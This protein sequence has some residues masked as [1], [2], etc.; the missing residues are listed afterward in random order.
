MAC[1]NDRNQL[2]NI[3]K[4]SKKLENEIICGEPAENMDHNKSNTFFYGIAKY[5]IPG[6]DDE[7]EIIDNYMVIGYEKPI[8]LN[9]IKNMFEC[10]N[11]EKRD[12]KGV[13]EKGMGVKHFLHKYADI[14][15]VISIKGNMI[16]SYYNMPLDRHINDLK[17]NKNINVTE[18]MMKLET[19]L[20]NQQLSRIFHSYPHIKT[21]YDKLKKSI[22]TFN[23]E[24]DENIKLPNSI[25]IIKLL[26]D[27]HDIENIYNDTKKIYEIKYIRKMNTYNYLLF[28]NFDNNEIYNLEIIKPVDLLMYKSKRDS[29]KFY[30][31]KY[32]QKYIF[33]FK[34]NNYF[35][36]YNYI[37]DGHMGNTTVIDKDHELYN[38]INN[39]NDN[40]EDFNLEI[41][42]ID[43]S[44]F[45]FFKDNIDIKN[46]SIE[47][48]TGFYFLLDNII[49]N[50]SPC[51]LIDVMN[52]PIRSVGG[53]STR[54][55]IEIKNKTIFDLRGVK[56]EFSIKDKKQKDIIK[57]LWNVLWQSHNNKLWNIKNYIPINKLI[58]SDIIV[59]FLEN[60]Y[61]SSITKK[62]NK[63]KE[64]K[65]E[66][67]TIKSLYLTLYNNNE[68]E[69]KYLAKI[70]FCANCKINEA[71]IRNGTTI[72]KPIIYQSYIN[73][74]INS[75]AQEIEN[76]IKN[77]LYQNT[78]INIQEK[79]NNITER[80]IFNDITIY[81]N[82]EKNFIK[83]RDLLLINN[84]DIKL[85]NNE[86][87][88]LWELIN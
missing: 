87:N 39:Y 48:Y 15:E 41:Y 77:F 24:N 53:T 33:Y 4:E 2:L 49:L 60:N 6:Y 16:E 71:N 62:K 21:I 73:T 28:N 17:N 11:D 18:N 34:H 12:D 7:K 27:L 26:D 45:N 32:K 25:I 13:P 64:Q 23:N 84:M 50:H 59:N 31:K 42:K 66:D 44:D 63:K 3:N 88:K 86:I 40:N 43:P 61:V 81:K 35:L 22:N 85:C 14:V 83:T 47:S 36:Y 55:I 70:G 65:K 1:I 57:F 29:F 54:Y 37:L 52:K 38:H 67:A 72:N 68:E 75:G 58:K 30:I 76:T 82:I 79:G 5:S 69:Y 9:N 20:I 19:T 51:S 80:F 46:A 74:L 8:P 56:P 10:N 78:E